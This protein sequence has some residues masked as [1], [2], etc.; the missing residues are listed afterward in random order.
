MSAR[1]EIQAP[2]TW[3]QPALPWMA[4]VVAL[5]LLAGALV[6]TLTRSAT[7]T[8]VPHPQP[9]VSTATHQDSGG[10]GLVGTGGVTRPIPYQPVAPALAPQAPAA[11]RT[12]EGPAAPSAPQTAS[13]W[14]F[15]MISTGGEL[16]PAPSS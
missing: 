5:V 12:A 2:S 1:V 8:A 13:G 10:P 16:H 9:G 6:W 11:P 3:R 15:R 14:S 7:P 4:A